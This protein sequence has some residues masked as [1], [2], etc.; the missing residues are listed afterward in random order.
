[1][2]GRT[3]IFYRE[4]PHEVVVEKDGKAIAVYKSVEELVEHHIK[5]LLARDQQDLKR[6][7]NIYRD[8]GASHG[9]KN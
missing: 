6:V 5:G 3:R 1:M 8:S 4:S 2:E 7:R 9:P